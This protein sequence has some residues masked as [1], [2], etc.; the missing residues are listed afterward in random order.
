MIKEPEYKICSE[1]DI[2]QILEVYKQSYKE[3]YL[4][5]WT[6]NGENYMNTSFTK[7]KIISEM[8]VPQTQFYLIYDQELAIGVLKINNNKS[9]EGK[10]DTNALEIERLYF[11]KEAAGKGLGKA[12]LKMVLQLAA[13]ENKKTI[14][15][16]AMKCSDALKFY[17]KQNFKVTAEM[18]LTY[19]F[20]KDE[21]K[22]MVVMEKE[23]K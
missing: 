6:D 19:P 23:V 4:Y 1:D 16:K 14:W 9:A 12:T 3:H 20:I 15:L 18:D 13:H 17:E 8:N 21:L 22:G 11:L 7:E 2:P 10:K 5:L